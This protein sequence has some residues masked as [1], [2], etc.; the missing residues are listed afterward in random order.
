LVGVSCWWVCGCVRLRGLWHLGLP[1]WRPGV[2]ATT[3]LRPVPLAW[4]LL[5]LCGCGGSVLLRHRLSLR[6]LRGCFRCAPLPFRSVPFA[7]FDG[8]SIVPFVAFDGGWMVDRRCCVLW[9]CLGLRWLVG[10]CWL[11]DWAWV[12]G[13]VVGCCLGGVGR[14]ARCSVVARLGGRWAR[15]LLGLSWVVGGGCWCLLVAAVP[16]PWLDVVSVVSG[17]GSG[18]PSMLALCPFGV[19]F[20][21]WLGVAFPLVLS[22]HKRCRRARARRLGRERSKGERRDRESRARALERREEGEQSV[23]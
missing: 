15:W 1:V 21:L 14:W 22:A 4:C 11:L 5:V 3:N 19:P 7:A 10:F 6:C 20:D 12:A 8:G 23:D 13:L 16:L 17:S 9:R 2:Q 18:A